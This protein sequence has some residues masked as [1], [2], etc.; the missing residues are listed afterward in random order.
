MSGASRFPRRFLGGPITEQLDSMCREIGGPAR[1][2]GVTCHYHGR[3]SG[4]S[5][6]WSSFSF[7][8]GLRGAVIV[9][10]GQH[11]IIEPVPGD[12]AFRHRLLP[13]ADNGNATCGSEEPP[14]QIGRRL[15][16][17]EDPRRET[18][19]HDP[20]QRGRRDALAEKKYVELVMVADNSEYKLLNRDVN[21]LHTRMLEI[22]NKMDAYYRE[23]NVRVVLVGVEIWTQKD[24]IP[25]SGDPAQTLQR[26][27]SWRERDLV[28]RVQHDNAQLLTGRTLEGSAVGMATMN[29]M[30]SAERSGG[31]NRDHSVSVVGVASTM[32]H[33]LGHNLGLKHETPERMCGLPTIGKQWIMEKS[34]GFMPGLQF[35]RC[36]RWDLEAELQQGGGACLY[37]VPSPARVFGGP[38]CGNLVVEKGEQCD[39]GLVLE[40]ADPCCNASSCQLVAGAQCSG[41]GLCCAQ[42]KLKPPGAPCR[43]PTG[44]CDLPEYCTGVSGHCPPNVYLQD[45]EPCAGGRAYC[46]HGECPTLHSQCQSLWGPGSPPAPES[47]VTHLNMR[48]DKYGNCGRRNGTYLPCAMRDSGCGA[49]QCRGSAL[50]GSVPDKVTI[51][52]KANGSE[53]SC[54]GFYFN[55]G[56]DVSDPIMVKDGTVCGAGKVCIRQKCEDASELRAQSCREKCSGRGVCNSN[57]NC[58]C[59]PGWAPPDCGTYGE[60]GSSDSGPLAMERGGQS[61]TTTLLIV[62]LVLIA[63]LALCY[64]TRTYLRRKLAAIFSKGSQCQ[65]RS[66]PTGSQPRPLRPPPPHRA[67]STELQVMSSA[68]QVPAMDSRLRWVLRP[69]VLRASE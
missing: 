53:V 6:P 13:L 59:A 32:A 31:V 38:R 41:D 9:A 34:S 4:V 63:L 14:G 2:F 12:G 29:S 61:L 52:V 68:N 48:G 54:N 22:A 42:C 65:Y 3:V 36:S 43:D 33:A 60:G 19:G 1:P 23:L 56:E 57:N 50:P 44:E 46:Y 35:S 5:G 26:F 55:L 67:Q 64:V 16:S 47:C 20:A 7:C 40:C 62:F 11:Y 69:Q 17:M 37:N 30:C 49:L 45:G 51:K 66:T 28:P 10:P 25:V 15:L 21:A 39:C 18:P 58:H 27:L 24:K 8:S